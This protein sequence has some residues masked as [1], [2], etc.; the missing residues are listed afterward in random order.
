M[1][2][3][4]KMFERKDGIVD[5]LKNEYLPGTRVEL[6][7]MKDAFSTL[8]PGDRGTVFAVDDIGTIHVK[9]DCGSGLG[10]A[11]GEDS[12]KKIMEWY[13]VWIVVPG[14]DGDIENGPHEP[15]GWQDYVEANS[16]ADAIEKA[17]VF[18]QT[19]WEMEDP[20]GYSEKASGVQCPIC[21]R[22]IRVT[23]EE[24]KAWKMAMELDSL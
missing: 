23:E 1:E 18:V 8:H 6:V 21:T 7:L 5:A 4:K 20:Y 9:W 10:I 2:G 22:A 12:C 15:I 17:G 24:Y 16:E 13:Q 14:T 3:M 11:Y 19:D